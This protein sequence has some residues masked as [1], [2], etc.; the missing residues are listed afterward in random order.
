MA[1]PQQLQGGLTP[2]EIEF[3]GEE[4]LITVVPSFRAGPLHLISGTFG[5]FL[6]LQQV[7]LP[8]WLAMT[9]IRRGRCR[10]ITPT[11][12]TVPYLL[13]RLE[14][15]TSQPNFSPLPSRYVEVSQVLL[16]GARESIPQVGKVRRM[17][18]ELREL[19]L[20][21]ARLGLRTLDG[22]YL[23]LDGLSNME[24]NEMRPVVI[25]SFK[26]LQRL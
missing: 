11:W 7:Q 8:L 20:A 22:H 1:L 24:I 2:S 6:P 4:V 15:E 12:L 3:R 16:D 5:P 18:Q 26:V 19:R 23:Q 21:K 9:L 14:E 17:L 10:L 13:K 25:E